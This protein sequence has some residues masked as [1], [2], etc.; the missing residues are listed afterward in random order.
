MH[1]TSRFLALTGLFGCASI[2]SAGLNSWTLTG[3]DGGPVSSIAI[4]PEQ[5]QIAITSTERGLYRTT[6]GGDNWTL[7]QDG[8]YPAAQRIIFD[9]TNL[10]RVFAVNGSIW[11]SENAGQ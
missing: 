6:N 5:S 1:A 11:R 7:V 2:A 9:P 8:V 10:N 4:H 3:P